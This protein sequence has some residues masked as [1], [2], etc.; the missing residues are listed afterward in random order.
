ML[1]PFRKREG[2]Y[3]HL[4]L[5]LTLCT[6]WA[7]KLALTHQLLMAI[8]VVAPTRAANFCDARLLSLPVILQSMTLAMMEMIHC[9]AKLRPI[10]GQMMCKPMPH[11]PQMAARP[12]Q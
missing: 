11:S 7:K 12:R 3:P 9:I 10:H 4:T 5:S 1:A 6:W 2:T 8:C